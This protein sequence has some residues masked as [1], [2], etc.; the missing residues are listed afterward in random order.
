MNF[1]NVE[2]RT[3]GRRT[4]MTAEQFCA[5]FDRDMARLYSLA[6]LLTG[7]HAAAETCFLAA[8]D[9]CRKATS[10]S[11]GWARSWAR[12]A[13]LKQAIARV[14]PAPAARRLQT[15]AA[16]NGAS[17]VLATLLE[18]PAFDRF[19]FAM[20]VLE[21][22]RMRECA[23]LLNCGTRQ[24]EEARVRALQYIAAQQTV[25]DGWLNAEVAGAAALFASSAA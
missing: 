20:N 18:M 7:E 15:K 23:A 19:V 22:Y 8:L 24:V 11:P 16:I 17:G 4:Y 3:N 2:F 1:R 14:Q 13:V 9:D 6:L 21:H 25:A 5:I 10:V 12:R